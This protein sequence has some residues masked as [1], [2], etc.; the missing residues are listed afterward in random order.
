MQLLED[1]KKTAHNIPELHRHAWILDY[2][3]CAG[4]SLDESSTECGV[5]IYHVKKKYWRAPEL[6]PLLHLIDCITAQA[7]NATTSKGS[8]RYLWLPGE[9]VILKCGSIS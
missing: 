7:K 9:G 5:K 3:G 2:L 4:M 1:C 6:H 8:Q